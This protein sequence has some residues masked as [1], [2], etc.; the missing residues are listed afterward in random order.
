MSPRSHSG[1]LTPHARQMCGACAVSFFAEPF[2][3]FNRSLDAVPTSM[4]DVT[5]QSFR[6]AHA[7]PLAKAQSF[8]SGPKTAFAVFMLDSLAVGYGLN[9]FRLSANRQD[10][11]THR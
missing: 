1:G 3:C 7:A 5:A 2:F 9:N 6:W 10:V 11:D 8:M 4:S